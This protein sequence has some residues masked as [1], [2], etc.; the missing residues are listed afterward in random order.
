MKALAEFIARGQIQ[1][2][3]VAFL[4]MASVFF[5]W[6]GAAAVAFCILRFGVNA[7]APIII[8]A[9][10]PASYWASVGEIGPLLTVLG[11]VV[12]A[13][14]L[15]AR[16]DWQTVL[17]LMPFVLV[18]LCAVVLFLAPNYVEGIRGLI[19]QFIVQLKSQLASS[20]KT[21]QVVVENL[22]APTSEQLM[23][24]LA[25]MQSL[26]VLTGL[27]LARWWQ[28]LLFN[29][30]GFQQE[31][32]QLRLNRMYVLVLVACFALLAGN[33]S[34][35]MWSWVFI[36]PIAVSGVAMVHGI[37]V[38]TQ[39]STHWL[40]L[41]Y[42]VLILVRPALPLLVA[43]AVIDSALDFRGRLKNKV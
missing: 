1:A 42:A 37:V 4:A 13:I 16:G 10:L 39:R 9:L 38:M 26:T 31:F 24:M 2:I 40:L 18:V 29:P 6:V 12:L 14:M 15:R 32:H 28:A 41:F 23:G 35:Q 5:A 33:A 30:G 7:A 36:L 19:E 3:A 43:L 17:L 22:I 25:L 8:A 27:I 20:G 34:Y 11:I 21:D